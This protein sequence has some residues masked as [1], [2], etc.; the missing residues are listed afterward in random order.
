MKF[1]ILL[2]AMV[3]TL[4]G[5]SGE[6]TA[7]SQGVILPE[8]SSSIEKMESVSQEESEADITRPDTAQSQTEPD[9]SEETEPESCSGNAQNAGGE[10]N[11]RAVS[12]VPAAETEPQ[13]SASE[14]EP[15]VTNPPADTQPP[16]AE[17]EIP[18][19]SVS[20]QIPVEPEPEPEAP[21]TI[22][23]YEFDAEAIRAELIALGQ[24]M[25]LTHITEDDGVPC[26]PDTC[27]WAS[28]VTASAS[29]QGDR[30][31]R[32]LNDYVTSMPALLAS[33]G[34]TEISCFT[35]Y[36]QDNGGGS[37]T[38]YFLY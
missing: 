8:K 15:A 3:L 16:A 24:S 33:Y 17:P 20:E 30:L 5:C 9:E 29:F 35:I 1:F 21:K 27:S 26:T 38:F 32:A 31:K 11:Q 7:K 19:S 25:G 34:G 18:E 22:Y 23:D 14:P 6:R 4:S 36:V 13:Q 2:L 12:T 10:T 37:Y 28:P